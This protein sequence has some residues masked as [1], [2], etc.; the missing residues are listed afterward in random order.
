MATL[1]LVCLAPLAVA[2][3][4]QAK[5]LAERAPDGVPDVLLLLALAPLL[6]AISALVLQVVV[7]A[8]EPSGHTRLSRLGVAIAMAADP[9]LVLLLALLVVPVAAPRAAPVVPSVV[10]ARL[11]RAA[12]AALSPNLRCR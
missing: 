1:I 5:R 12:L 2:R 9:A 11:A 4:A 7:G 10:A 3:A 8:R 6:P